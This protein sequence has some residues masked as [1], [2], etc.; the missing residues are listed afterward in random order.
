MLK[1]RFL[2]LIMIVCLFTISAVSA[3]KISNEINNDISIV[4]EEITV[5]NDGYKLLKMLIGGV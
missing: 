3:E 5:E 1:K 4:N 2:F